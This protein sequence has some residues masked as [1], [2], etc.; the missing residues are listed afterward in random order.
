[1]EKTALFEIAI[2]TDL[3]WITRPFTLSPRED[4]E[5][6]KQFWTRQSAIARSRFHLDREAFI[7][8]EICV[9]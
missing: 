5:A 4:G 6:D 1:M 2:S 8:R 9:S 7:L 3:G